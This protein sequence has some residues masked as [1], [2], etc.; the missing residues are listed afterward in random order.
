MNNLGKENSM[1]LIHF[2]GF[3]WVTCLLIREFPLNL[4]MRL[5]DTL[6]ADNEGFSVFITFVCASLFLK[7]AGKLKK[8]DFMD[9]MKFFQ[10]FH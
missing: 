2:A 5:F 7:W 4:S 1:D 3:K 9:T 10:N 8:L 6:I